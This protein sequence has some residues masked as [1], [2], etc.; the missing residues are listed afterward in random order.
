MY[1][2]RCLSDGEAEH[3]SEKPRRFDEPGLSA[4]AL[5][6]GEGYGDETSTECLVDWR[7]AAL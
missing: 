1:C 6:A 4:L 5:L 2:G 3:S 7:H